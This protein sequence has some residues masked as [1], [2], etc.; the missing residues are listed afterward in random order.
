MSGGLRRPSAVFRH[1]QA[2]TL[3][4][5]AF[6]SQMMACPQDRVLK[7]RQQPIEL[8]WSGPCLSVPRKERAMAERV[9]MPLPGSSQQPQVQTGHSM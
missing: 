2:D 5:G 7:A 9:P 4:V 3:S 6:C 1:L 8:G